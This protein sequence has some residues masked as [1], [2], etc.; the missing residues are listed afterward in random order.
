MSQ[1]TH[2]EDHVRSAQEIAKRALVLY[3][4]FNISEDYHENVQDWLTS[5]SLWDKLTPLELAYVTSISPTK[6]AQVNISWRSEAILVLLWA[7]G[8]IEQMPPLFERCD[9]EEFLRI[10]PPCVDTAVVQFIENATVRSEEELKSFEKILSDVHWEA[11]DALINNRST[12]YCD[13]GII[14]ERH[15]A[16]NWI[17]GYKGQSWDNITTDTQHSVESN[18]GFTAHLSSFQQIL[19]YQ[20][21][22]NSP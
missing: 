12:L 6:Q 11:R 21:E 18:P 17:M 10:L 1:E 5:K 8:A 13:I 9:H 7:L 15:H 22:P 4:I 14:Q 3:A 19:R 16:M 2:N 20:W